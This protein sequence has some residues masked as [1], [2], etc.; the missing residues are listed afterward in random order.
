IVDNKR[1]QSFNPVDGR[2]IP[3]SNAAEETNLQPCD[4]L[5]NGIKWRTSDGVW[6]SSSNT[7]IYMAF[8]ENPFV[9]SEGVPTTAR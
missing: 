1:T 6:N 4:F 9:S 3:N 2:L 8:A 7:H 5:S